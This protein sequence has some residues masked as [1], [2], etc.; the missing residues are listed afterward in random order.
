M[1]VLVGDT[2]DA[3]AERVQAREREFLVETLIAIVSGAVSLR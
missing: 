3:L 1:P 2:A